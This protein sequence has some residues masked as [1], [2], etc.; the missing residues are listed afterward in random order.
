MVAMNAVDETMS[1]GCF[2]DQKRLLLDLYFLPS[3]L[4]KSN[5]ETMTFFFRF[6]F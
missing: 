2:L 6:T 5:Q 1:K 4:K 3:F